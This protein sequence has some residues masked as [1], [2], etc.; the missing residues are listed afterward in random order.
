MK[1]CREFIFFVLI[2]NVLNANLFHSYGKKNLGNN[3]INIK[4]ITR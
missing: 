3:I 4:A 1:I 2:K